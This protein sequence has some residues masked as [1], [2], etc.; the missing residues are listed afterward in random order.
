MM[1]VTSFTETCMY[2]GAVPVFGL[3]LNQLRFFV[4]AQSSVPPPAL[5]IFRLALG[6]QQQRVLPP[7]NG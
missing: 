7:E 5:V 6:K 4:A 1:P 3:I 2:E